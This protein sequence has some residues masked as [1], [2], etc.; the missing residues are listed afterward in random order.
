M[1]RRLELRRH[2]PRDPDRDAL[3]P[4]GEALA[5]RVGRILRGP[6]DAVFT[7]PKERAARTAA[8]FLKGLGQKLPERH[9]VAEGLAPPDGPIDAATASALGAEVRRLLEAVPEG[10]TGLAVGHTP[11]LEEA[12]EALT[13]RRIPPLAECQGVLLREEDGAVTVERE[14]R[15]D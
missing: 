6:Y 3:S 1:A 9:G 14:L 2:A 8:F 5:E 4:E 12:V 11:S 7:S 10:R 13:G 15:P